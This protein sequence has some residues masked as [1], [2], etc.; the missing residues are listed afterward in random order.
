MDEKILIYFVHWLLEES[1]HGRIWIL[2]LPFINYIKD[3]NLSMPLELTLPSLPG[4]LWEVNKIKWLVTCNVRTKKYLFLCKKIWKLFLK[5]ESSMNKGLPYLNTIRILPFWRTIF[6]P[7]S[8]FL[9][10][11]LL[12]TIIFHDHK[13]HY[14]YACKKV[15]CWI[16]RLILLVFNI[17]NNQIWM[18]LRLS[19]IETI[20]GLKCRQTSATYPCIHIPKLS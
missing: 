5:A 2:A 14:V 6:E 4:H 11:S 7:T 8:G 9:P 16:F 10:P 17:I 19:R 12:W 15:L 1:E 3:L 18:F 13:I 20:L